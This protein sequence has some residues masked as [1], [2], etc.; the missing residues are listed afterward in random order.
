MI[1]V[2]LNTKLVQRPQLKITL[3]LLQ[4]GTLKLV[5]ISPNK[6]IVVLRTA[7]NVVHATSPEAFAHQ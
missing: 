7:G 4:V 5:K 1:L 6:I 2:L 3:V